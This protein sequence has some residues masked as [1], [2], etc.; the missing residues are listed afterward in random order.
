MG[1]VTLRTVA[2]EAGVS[3]ST[4]SNAY[5][6]PDQLSAEVRTRVEEARIEQSRSN[7]EAQAAQVAL[8]DATREFR[9]AQRKLQEIDRNLAQKTARLKLLQ[10]LQEKWE[11]FG[12]GAKALLQGRFTSLFGEQKFVPVTQGLEV[13]A[14]YAKAVEAILGSSVEAISVSAICR[15]PTNAPSNIAL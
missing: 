10:Q 2:E 4:V 3:V 11:G 15:L 1:G 8:Q 13:R 6:R 14:E 12:E 7:N 5:N 9:D